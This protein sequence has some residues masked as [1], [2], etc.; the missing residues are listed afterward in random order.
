MHISSKNILYIIYDIIYIILWYIIKKRKG[1]IAGRRRR[2]NKMGNEN[3]KWTRWKTLDDVQRYVAL[4]CSPRDDSKAIRRISALKLHCAVS[5]FKKWKE[6]KVLFFFLIW[7]DFI[8]PSPKKPSLDVIL[9]DII[10]FSIRISFFVM[11]RFFFG[12]LVW[13]FLSERLR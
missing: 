6:K 3:K 7:F 13:L 9:F 2:W 5:N 10:I 8:M 12:F 4:D 1:K 11:A